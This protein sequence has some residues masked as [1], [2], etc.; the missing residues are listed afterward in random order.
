MLISSQYGYFKLNMIRNIV[1]WIYWIKT[2]EIILYDN[3]SAD[4][5]KI[6]IGNAYW[7][8]LDLIMN[9]IIGID[10]Q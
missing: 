8:M 4:S 1:Y 3:K 9:S 10:L 6:K 2:A 5:Y 7:E